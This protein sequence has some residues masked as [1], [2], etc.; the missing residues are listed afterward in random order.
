MTG[1]EDMSAAAGMSGSASTSALIRLHIYFI[2]SQNWVNF[3]Q[4]TER[5]TKISINKSLIL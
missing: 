2:Q 3:T 5:A 1:G 4:Q